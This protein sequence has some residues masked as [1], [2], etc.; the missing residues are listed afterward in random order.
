MKDELASSSRIRDVIARHGFRFSKSLGQNFLRDASVVE[1]IVDSAELTPEDV[2]IEI[3]PGIGVMTDKL[4]QQAGRVLAVE[5]DQALFPILEETLA[6]HDNVTLIHAD[7]LKLDLE[8]LKAEY[9]PDRS[10]KIVANLPY[11]I[12][13]P[14]IMK[15]LESPMVFSAMVVMMQKEVA[16]RM[17]APPGGKIYGALS[18]MVQYHTRVRS[19]LEVPRGAFVPEPKVLSTVLRLDPH[20]TAPVALEDRAMFSRTVK[21]AF[22]TRRKTLYNALSNDFDKPWVQ[23]ALEASGIDPG[24][25]AEKLDMES[26]GRLANAFAKTKR[27]PE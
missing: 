16:Q 2:V 25:R 26:F 20:E 15:F 6:H 21:A 27:A 24:L 13:T 12:T 3:G 1:R 22:S 4:A 11:Y 7:V 23:R 18:V 19:V 8:Q 10:P 14:I 17:V 5:I 9:F